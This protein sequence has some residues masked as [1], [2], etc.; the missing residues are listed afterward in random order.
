[1]LIVSE[2]VYIYLGTAA[3]IGCLTGGVVFIFFKLLSSSLHID[4]APLPQPRDRSRTTAEFRAASRKKKEGPFDPME[5]PLVS[6]A[7]VLD[8]VVGSRRKG[9]L[10]QAIV[11]SSRK[12][13]TPD[14]IKRNGLEHHSGRASATVSARL[15]LILLRGGR[16]ERIVHICWSQPKHRFWTCRLNFFDTHGD[17]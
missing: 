16:T 14:T 13:L 6:T 5:Y 12:T 9:L 4:S 8:K 17:T 3:L 2:T 11:A 15:C 10:L 7:A 1:M